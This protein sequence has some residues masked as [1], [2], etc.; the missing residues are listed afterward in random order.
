MN[1]KNKNI[2][3]RIYPAPLSVEIYFLE[4][5]FETMYGYI[6][7]VNKLPRK[8]ELGLRFTKLTS[9]AN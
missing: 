9:F 6:A 7:F 3:M 1:T 2:A 5:L 8:V 4:V